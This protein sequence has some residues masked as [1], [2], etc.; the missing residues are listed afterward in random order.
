MLEGKNRMIAA[1][2]SSNRKSSRIISDPVL[3][4]LPKMKELNLVDRERMLGFN[5]TTSTHLS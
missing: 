3:E 2:A 5:G 4:P 1:G